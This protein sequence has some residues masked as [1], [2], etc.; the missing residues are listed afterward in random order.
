MNVNF[1]INDLDFAI[2]ASHYN[3][4]FI[5]TLVDLILHD[6]FKLRWKKKKFNF[7]IYTISALVSHG[8]VYRNCTFYS[9]EKSFTHFFF[10]L[11]ETFV[12]DVWWISSMRVEK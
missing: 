5:H 2:S 3:I 7:H 1:Y 10:F 8:K 11:K 9:D 4:L 6:S 12:S